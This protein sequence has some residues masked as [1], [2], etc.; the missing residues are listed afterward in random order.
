MI[1]MQLFDV[2]NHLQDERLGTDREAVMERAR[3]AGLTGMA[4]CGTTEADWPHVRAL[5]DAH[6]ERIIPCYGLHPWWIGQRSP[7]WLESL[8]S[9]LRRERAAVGEIGLDHARDERDDADQEAVFL[10][11]LAVSH[12]LKR[13]VAIHCRR[14]WG[15]MLEL[16][17]EAGPHPTGYLLHAYSG[18]PDLVKQLTPLNAW[19]SFG[20]SLTYPGNRRAPKA[21]RAVPDD[22]LLLETDAPDI[23]PHGYDRCEPAHLRRGL[24]AASDHLGVDEEILARRTRDN[25]LTL[26]AGL[27]P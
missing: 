3:A 8:V 1:R 10:A 20:G 14:A 6:R 19:F 2:H 13:P 18:G 27:T 23:P 7:S 9:R 25:A 5:A 16:L 11:Q 15:R 26:F 12:D 22:R 21:L 17:R 24:R 4:V